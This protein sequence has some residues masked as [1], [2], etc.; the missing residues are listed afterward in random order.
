MPWM[1]RLEDTFSAMLPAQQRVRFNADEFMRAD[2][3]TRVRSHQV[4]ISSG[5][6]TPNEARHIE[7]REPYEGGNEFVLGL[8]GAP[9]VGAD[10][11]PFIGTDAKT[12]N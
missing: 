2:L 8:Q 11:S 4:Q 10:N 1:R 3:A 5:I 9:V 6:L 7:G 12:I